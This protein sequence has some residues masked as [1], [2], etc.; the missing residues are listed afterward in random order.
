MAAD[1][2]TSLQDE[3]RK[4]FLSY[5]E[6]YLDEV[7]RKSSSMEPDGKMAGMMYKVKMV[8]DWL[9][10]IVEKEGGFVNTNSEDS[11]AEAYGRV[12]NK[13]YGILLN[14]VERTAIAF[15]RLNGSM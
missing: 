11:E 6:K 10:V 5:V 4:L 3:C 14:H 2:A 7:D 15:E 1:L 12:R 9:D 8:S 13:I